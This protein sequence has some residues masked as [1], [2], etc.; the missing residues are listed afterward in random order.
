ME[1]IGEEKFFFE[2]LARLLSSQFGSNCEVVVHD[3]T[4]DYDHTI[5]VIENGHV[6]NRKVGDCGSN[7]GLEVLRGTVDNG[8]RFGYITHTPSGKVLR[9]ST[10][11][12][13]NRSDE[14]IGA[15]CV[16]L[17]IS[18][19]TMVDRVFRELFNFEPEAAPRDREGSDEV[20][21]SD[22]NQLLDT[23]LRE[24][25]GQIG[26]P[27]AMMS[28]EDKIQVVAW[29]DSRGAFL[30]TK[31]G[32]RVCKQLDISKFTLYSYLEMAHNSRSGDGKKASA[33]KPGKKSAA[34][35]KKNAPKNAVRRNDTA[36]RAKS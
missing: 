29:L 21:A 28:R 36:K 12:L 3:L 9:S 6:T 4:G 24:A 31:A 18:G 34:S 16:N 7:L 25:L 22:V 2:S 20:F 27:V 5:A 26:K 10:I 32:V 33:A 30:I 17:D 1:S 23:L 13:R 19:V 14:V 11:Y 8:D 15:V 35:T